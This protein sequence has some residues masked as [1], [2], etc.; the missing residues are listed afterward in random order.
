MRILET[1]GG[2]PFI[3]LLCLQAIP[4]R[5]TVVT[6]VTVAVSGPFLAHLY[7]TSQEWLEVYILH[8]RK[9]SKSATAQGI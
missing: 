4:E 2:V 1:L 3:L 6:I 9:T 7:L 5:R 8:S